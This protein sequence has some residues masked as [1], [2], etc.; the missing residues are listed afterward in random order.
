MALNACTLT[1][2]VTA[3]ANS[4]ACRMDDDEL[5]VMA[6]MFTQLGDTLALIALQRG[7][8]AEKQH[9]EP[10]ETETAQE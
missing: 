2:A 3:A 1:A 8:C 4:L 6:A 7:I 10:K 9:R 5:A